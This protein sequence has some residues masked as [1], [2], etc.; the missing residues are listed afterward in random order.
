MF[1]FFFA[2]F[3]VFLSGHSGARVKIINTDAEG[4]LVLCD[5]LSHLRERA[6]NE[7]LQN[8]RIIS[9]ATLTGHAKR[10][11]GIYSIAMDNG[12]ARKANIANRI[13]VCIDFYYFLFFIYFFFLF[14]MLVNIMVKLLSIV[15]LEEM[16]LILIKVKTQ[17]MMFLT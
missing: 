16:I 7:N 11:V 13:I 12:P 2:N 8:V 3:H 10:S 1:L 14:R 4:R 5:C 6:I 17:L 15:L 9:T